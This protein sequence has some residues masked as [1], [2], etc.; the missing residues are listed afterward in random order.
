MRSLLFLLLLGSLASCG[1][2]APLARG[3]RPRPKL[4]LPEDQLI[5]TQRIEEL[6]PPGMP[7]ELAKRR[8]ERYGFECT[9]GDSLG[10]Q[11]LYCVQSKQK[12]IWPF[13]GTWSATIYHDGTVR[14]IQGR[15]DLVIWDVG[16]PISRHAAQR[17]ANRPDPASGARPP[18]AKQE[19]KSAVVR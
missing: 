9:Y 10:I 16:T 11:Y 3:P 4:F 18:L 2:S 19:K 15:Y 7:I 17:A 8:M 5:T 14:N 12:T 13:L 6:I 1:C